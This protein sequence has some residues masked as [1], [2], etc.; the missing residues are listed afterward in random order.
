MKP[1]Y[2]KMIVSGGQRGA[3]RGALYAARQLGYE[4]GGWV[5]LDRRAEDGQVPTCFPMTRCDSTAYPTRTRLNVECSD[6][7]LLFGYGEPTGGTALTITIAESLQRKYLFVRLSTSTKARDVSRQIRRWLAETRPRVLNVAGQRE[8]KAP[9]IQDQVKQ[10]M[11]LVLQQ[12]DRCI[13]S[14]EIPQEILESGKIA[15]CSACGH[16]TRLEDFLP[17]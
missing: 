8:S 6:V 17:G 12:P 4:H 2:P 16:S 15:H 7:T 10:I 3:D 1:F 9:G 11:L 5:T 13:C 14:K